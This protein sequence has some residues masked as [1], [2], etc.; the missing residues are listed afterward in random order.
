VNRALLAELASPC[1]N[2]CKMD[3]HSGLCQGCLRS[4]DEIIGWASRSADERFRIHALVDK[5]RAAYGS[6]GS[7]AGSALDELRGECER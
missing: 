1:I 4:L 2:V 6:R 5:R 3:A 7:V